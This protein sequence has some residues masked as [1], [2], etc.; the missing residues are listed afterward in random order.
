MPFPTHR[1]SPTPER[2]GSL[3][4]VFDSSYAL[5][6]ASE[7]RLLCCLAVFAGG[8]TLEAAEAVCGEALDTPEAWQP[9]GTQHKRRRQERPAPPQTLVLLKRLVEK[10]LVLFHENSGTGTEQ[11][12]YQLLEMTRQ[13]ALEQFSPEQRDQAEQRHADYFLKQALAGE[14]EVMAG[15]T[16]WR[17]MPKMMPDTENYYAALQRWKQ[18]DPDQALLLL[19]AMGVCGLVAL[20]SSEVQEG[21]QRLAAQELPLPSPLQ[22]KLYFTVA[23]WACYSTLPV[24]RALM[25]QAYALAEGCG[26]KQHMARALWHLGI[27]D[28]QAGNTESARKRLEAALDYSQQAGDPA[29]AASAQQQLI[30]VA[31]A[32]HDF[33]R[34]QSMAEALLHSGREQNRWPLTPAL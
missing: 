10:S 19:I 8:W 20:H 22:A 27:Q 18:T 30:Y 1:N 32:E 3:Q 24:G 7:Q 28:M 29:L 11:P 2:H 6:D 25:E 16:T 14:A 31:C 23:H 12:R 9:V 13:Y 33:A 4:A 17:R 21:I 15:E 26:D 34:A 5:L